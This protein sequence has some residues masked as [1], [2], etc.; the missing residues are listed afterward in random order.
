[1]GKRKVSSSYQTET[2]H[3]TEGAR[4]GGCRGRRKAKNLR[5]LQ[6]HAQ[7]RLAPRRIRSITKPPRQRRIAQIQISVHQGWDAVTSKADIELGCLNEAQ[8]RFT[9]SKDAPLLREPL[10]S[11][12]GKQGFR[13]AVPDILNGTYAPPPRTDRCTAA[14][15]DELSSIPNTPTLLTGTHAPEYQ[16]GWKKM[17]ERT[18]SGPSGLHFGHVKACMMDNDLADFQSSLSNMS[19]AT[20]YS[21]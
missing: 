9:Q 12:V 5:K 2:I 8:S 16:S 11:E 1:M 7:Q 4:Y 21:P 19:F 18:S 6:A 15:L 14:F 13:P 20:G 3:G 17:K 10:L